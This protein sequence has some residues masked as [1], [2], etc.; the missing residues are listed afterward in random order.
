MSKN[1]KCDLSWSKKISA[2]LYSHTGDFECTESLR[3]RTESCRGRIESP[4]DTGECIPPG[5]TIDYSDN[6]ST[7]VLPHSQ[8]RMNRVP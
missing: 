2:L 5:K 6:P 3:G 7:S 8:F 1:V 4:K